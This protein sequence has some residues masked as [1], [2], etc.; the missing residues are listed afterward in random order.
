[1]REGGGWNMRLKDEQKIISAVKRRCAK[2]GLKIV[3]IKNKPVYGVKKIRIE[4]TITNSNS[5]ELYLVINEIEYQRKCRRRWYEV[6]QSTMPFYM[7]YDNMIE[8]FKQVVQ[9]TTTSCKGRYG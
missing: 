9:E 2:H 4:F 5:Q 1:L 6:I 8:A 7:S 3:G